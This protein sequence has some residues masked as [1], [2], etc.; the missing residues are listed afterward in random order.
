MTKGKMVTCLSLCCATHPKSTVTQ[1][2]PL[3]HIGR[4]K[5]LPNLDLILPQARKSDN[6]QFSLRS[7]LK[8]P[9]HQIQATFIY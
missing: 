4:G 9:D 3:K 7:G 8:S 6:I 5:L 2:G 1:L